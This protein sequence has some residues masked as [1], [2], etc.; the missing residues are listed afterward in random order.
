MKAPDLTYLK[1]G[2][3]T[4]FI[5]QSKEGEDAWREIAKQTDGTGKVFTVQLLATLKQLKKAG[6]IVKQSEK[7]SH[8]V[9]R[10]EMAEIM[11]ELERGDA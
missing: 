3:F 8:E 6:Y 9:L 1:Q 11:K 2:L 10:R 7:K 5:A 4:A